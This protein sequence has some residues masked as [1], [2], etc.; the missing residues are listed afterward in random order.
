MTSLT[1]DG[2]TRLYGIVCDP[3]AQ[4]KTPELMNAFFQQN[5]I[6]AVY[7]PLQVVAATF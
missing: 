5:G 3:I 1:I 7:V 2:S 6:N 4:V